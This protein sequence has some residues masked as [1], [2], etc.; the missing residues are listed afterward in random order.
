MKVRNSQELLASKYVWRV[1]VTKKRFGTKAVTEAANN[2]ATLT[3]TSENK[4]KDDRNNVNVNI[5]IASDAIKVTMTQ[6]SKRRC[7]L[8]MR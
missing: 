8:K 6:S 5:S 2:N 1:R 7:Q 3:Q 4:D